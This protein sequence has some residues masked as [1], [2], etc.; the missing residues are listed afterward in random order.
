M[1]LVL[2]A[3]TWIAMKNLLSSQ[4]GRAFEAL[5]DSPIA[6]DAMG[7]G[8]FRH[9]VG[10]FALGSGLGGL[11][12]GLY[13]FNF[14]FLQP[15]SFVYELMVILLL[16]VVLGG[17]KSLWGAFVGACLI[18]LLP[19]LLSNR[20][21]FQVFSFVGLFLAL[22]AARAQFPQTS[23]DFIPGCRTDCQ[24]GFA[25]GWQFAGREYRRLAQ[26]HLCADA[27][28][29]SG[30]AARR[31]DGLCRKTTDP[32]VQSTGATIARCLFA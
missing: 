18:V 8:V 25:G 30:G 13:A 19:N 12:G 22:I 9:K 29:G 24:H 28:L 14:Q 21:L 4:W 2:L 3:L 31:G 16:G 7:V 26:S 17:R 11:A 27:V 20:T 15:G 10:A 6:T 5:R 23:P 32:P 1:C